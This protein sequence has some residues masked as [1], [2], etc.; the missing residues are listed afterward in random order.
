MS[1]ETVLSG[2]SG[3]RDNIRSALTYKGLA[4]SSSVTL[5]EAAGLITLLPSSGA[6]DVSSTTADAADVLAGKIFYTSGGIQTSGTIPTVS[7]SLSFNTVIVPSGYIASS[8]VLSVQ[9]RMSATVSE[10]IVTIPPG[11]APNTEKISVGSAVSSATII[12]TTSNLVISSGGYLIG[13]QTIA[14]DSNLVGSN[15]LSGV[16][17]FGVPGTI[18]II[19]SSSY[20]PGTSDQLISSGQYLGGIQ[21]ILGD[22]NLVASNIVSGVSV[23]GVAGSLVPGLDDLGFFDWYTI[24]NNQ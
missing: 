16:N 2:L 15:I 12:P 24:L 19:G 21:T 7:A 13:D 18:P 10:N 17:I 6:V 3:A 23:F 1:L 11:Y 9:S 8:Q 20:T 5:N 22:A 14:G 4:V